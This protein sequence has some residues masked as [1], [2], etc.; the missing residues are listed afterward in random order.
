MSLYKNCCNGSRY[1]IDCPSCLIEPQSLVSKSS[2]LYVLHY[3][4]YNEASSRQKK[5]SFCWK[6]ASSRSW[7][8]ILKKKGF[9]SFIKRHLFVQEGSCFIKK[10]LISF[11]EIIFCSKKSLIWFMK[12]HILTFCSEKASS[13]SPK[14]PI[15]SFMKDQILMFCPKKALSVS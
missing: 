10:G 6:K 2:L 7:R 3:V 11:E 4:S 9:I 13:R 5:I 14:G 8:I 1:L 15:S 12:D